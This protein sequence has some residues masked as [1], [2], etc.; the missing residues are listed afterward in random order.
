M[1][2]DIV[3][4][5]FADGSRASFRVVARRSYPKSDL[6][7]NLFDRAGRS[8]LVLVTCGGSFDEATGSYDDNVVVF[9]VPRT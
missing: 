5:D 9:A 2:G 7:A 1:P 6:P 3:H 4:V 8:I